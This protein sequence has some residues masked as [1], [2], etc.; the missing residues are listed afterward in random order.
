MLYAESADV[1]ISIEPLKAKFSQTQ[2][3]NPRDESS[4]RVIVNQGRKLRVGHNAVKGSIDVFRQ[5]TVN[6]QML[7]L[8][9]E[10]AGL[11]EARELGKVWKMRHSWF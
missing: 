10:A 1:P 9:F 4:Y 3:L 7:D 2:Y 6:L 11:H 5:I 8:A